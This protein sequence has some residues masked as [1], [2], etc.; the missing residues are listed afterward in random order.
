LAFLG[1]L[2]LNLMPCVLP[3][4]SMKA[5]SL[6]VGRDDRHLL[7]GLAY[8]AGVLLSFLALA[9]V[10]V[11]LRRGGEAL[12]WG[13][14]MQSPRTV[15]ILS[16]LMA[17]MALSLWGVF[18]PGASFAGLGSTSARG[19]AGSF[20]TGVLAT[21]VATP[22]TAP[23]MG[24]AIGWALVL[25]DARVFAVFAAL[26]FGLAAPYLAISGIPKARRFLPR[27]GEWMVVLKQFFGFAM[28]ATAVWLAWIVGRLAGAD[29][30]ALVAA[31]WVVVALGA[32]ILGRGALPHHSAL[33]RNLSRIA[34]LILVAGSVAVAARHLPAQAQGLRAEN[35]G[36]VFRAGTLEELR[37]SR[38]PWLLVFTADWCLSCQ[39]NERVALETPAVRR[40]L[41]GKGV[42]V[43]K[44]DWTARD[45]VV[46]RALES[47]GRQGV[48][49]Y[50]LSNGSTEHALP[51]LLTA[52]TVL[53]A[54]DSL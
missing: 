33:R 17:L 54:L 31:L 3:V 12:G 16:L 13:F 34:F 7:H 18:E 35:A 11:V 50:V 39:V 52:S 23:F 2:L 46:S 44:A 9:A 8:T 41:E 25:P 21:V 5:L 6:I 27:P 29:S 4:L 26:A 10:L 48:P 47:F 38:K 36:E 53:A 37:G 51:E 24:S 32:W 49:F 14:Q 40:A 1:G 42:R 30:L 19:V 22:C 45:S 20:L 15:A 28:A 43:V